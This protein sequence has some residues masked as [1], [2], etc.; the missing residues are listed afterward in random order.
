MKA[1]FSKR[2]GAFLIDMVIVGVILGILIFFLP[3]S[4]NVKVINQNLSII[5]EEVLDGTLPVRDY[6]NE[7]I[8][9][10]SSL[11][12]ENAL[13]SVC[14]AFIIIGYFVVFAYINDGRTFG[15]QIMKIKVARKDE[16]YLTIKD[17]LIR[18]F[19]NYGLL[20]MMVSLAFVYIL[21]AT[22]YFIITSVI[23]FL[24]ILIII[25]SIFM[26]LYRKDKRSLSDIFSQTRV[27]QIEKE[28]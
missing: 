23:S 8:K 13:Q 10:T 15:K 27:I 28:V 7:F 22:P 4:E 24:Q 1:S 11:D 3:K 14:N 20:S 12:K 16:N 25:A 26:V 18:A 9:L 21:P 17:L 19:F 6:M 2:L 5:Y